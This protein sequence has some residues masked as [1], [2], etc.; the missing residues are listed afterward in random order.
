MLLRMRTIR[1]GGIFLHASKL[2]AVRRRSVE[3][4]MEA[5]VPAA[6]ASAEAPEAPAGPSQSSGGPSSSEMAIYVGLPLIIAV[7]LAIV[8]LLLLL[9]YFVLRAR[10]KQRYSKVPRKEPLTNLSS[11]PYPTLKPPAIMIDGAPAPDMSFTVAPQLPDPA[12]SQRYPF[13]KHKRQTNRTIREGGEKDKKQHKKRGGNWKKK[14]VEEKGRDGD[15]G[16]HSASP[17]EISPPREA[18]KARK[19]SLVSLS[20][21]GEQHAISEAF[22]LS[23]AAKQV[24]R[25][26]GSADK[27]PEIFFTL[28]Y[29][30]E[31]T[32]LVV[33]V[34]RVVGL[35]PRDD[36]AEVDAYVRLFFVP[37]LPEMAQRKTSKT[38]TA[39]RALDPVFH[40]EIQYEAMSEEELINSTLHVQ[41]LDYRAYGRHNII[42]QSE[43][44]LGQVPLGKDKEPVMLQLHP[45][46]VSE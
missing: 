10:N 3:K 6:S 16:T 15:S 12:A 32:T 27:L 22:V 23:A 21:F 24:G 34:E 28:T 40:E 8:A 20:Q 46:R 33:N 30:K 31:K 4:G 35:P 36:G 13:I 41:V 43:L 1:N 38:R 26:P 11:L 18:G 5:T 17:P 37:R 19:S 42:G 45:L 9:I 44:A 29:L 25:D 39:K 14:A 7:F 2:G